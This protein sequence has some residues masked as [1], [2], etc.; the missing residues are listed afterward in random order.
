M[1][2]RVLSGH[3]CLVSRMI[4]IENPVLAVESHQD[5]KAKGENPGLLI[6]GRVEMGTP[7]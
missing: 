2:L 7:T 4:F 5:Y 3:T 1:A 6:P